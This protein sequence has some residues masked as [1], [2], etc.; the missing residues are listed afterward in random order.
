[1][2]FYMVWPSSVF[3]MESGSWADSWQTQEKS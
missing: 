3:L 1:M 2:L